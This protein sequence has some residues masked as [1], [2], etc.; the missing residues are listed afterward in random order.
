MLDI[1]IYIL[2][3]QYSEVWYSIDKKMLIQIFFLKCHIRAY[4]LYECYNFYLAVN[5]V[6]NAYLIYNNFKFMFS[7]Y[8]NN[9]I[10]FKL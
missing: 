6:L 4:K 5:V 10:V 7:K 9:F 1:K 8:W 3:F 2:I